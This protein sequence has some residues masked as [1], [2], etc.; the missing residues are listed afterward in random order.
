MRDCVDTVQEQK[1]NFTYAYMHFGNDERS[2]C[3]VR[4]V[5]IASV[6]CDHKYTYMEHLHIRFQ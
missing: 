6:H 2:V 3:K 5:F 4:P 1:V